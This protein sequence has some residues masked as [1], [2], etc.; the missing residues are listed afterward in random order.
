MTP[1]FRY[2]RNSGE[3]FSNIDETDEPNKHVLDNNLILKC[4]ESQTSSTDLANI[5]SILAIFLIIST[6]SLL[7][8]SPTVLEFH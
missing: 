7:S 4:R 1:G 3:K 2:K 8:T 5:D 6:L